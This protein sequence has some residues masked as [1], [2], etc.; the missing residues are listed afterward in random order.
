MVKVTLL[1]QP[2]GATEKPEGLM[3]V[4]LGLVTVSSIIRDHSIDDAIEHANAKLAEE[5]RKRGAR[6]VMGVGYATL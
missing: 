5:A 2:Y 6:F 1:K 3:G 4:A